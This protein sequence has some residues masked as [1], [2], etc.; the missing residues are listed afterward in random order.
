MQSTTKYLNN[1]EA[2]TPEWFL[3]HYMYQPTIEE[4][5]K[6][7]DRLAHDYACVLSYATLWRMSETNYFLS[8]IYSEIDDAQYKHI[9][10]LVKH[11]ILYGISNLDTKEE[12]IEYITNL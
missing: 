2:A 5:I 6:D 3:K 7:Y 8:D 9:K 12:I 4:K 1:P 11:D 10:W